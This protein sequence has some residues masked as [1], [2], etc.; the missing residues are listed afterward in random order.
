M[1]KI[2]AYVTNDGQ[3]WPDFLTA[4]SAATNKYA[5]AI[6]KM[7]MKLVKIEKY[8]QM[9]DF[10]NCAVEGGSFQELLNLREDCDVQEDEQ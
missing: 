6:D 5:L 10:L 8:A 2:T 7:A 9:R 1:K 4:E 3:I